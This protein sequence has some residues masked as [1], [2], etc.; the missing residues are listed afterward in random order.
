MH[1]SNHRH[2]HT[3]EERLQ[4]VVSTNMHVCGIPDNYYDTMS[5]QNVY[6]ETSGFTN[7]VELENPAA[8]AIPVTCLLLLVF[9]F[10]FVVSLSLVLVIRFVLFP[11]AASSSKSYSPLML[12]NVLILDSSCYFYS[13][14]CSQSYS[15]KKAS[16]AA[17][18]HQVQDKVQR[19]QGRYK[20]LKGLTRALRAL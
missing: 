3:K 8:K 12:T 20:P 17:N 7:R 5:A 13:F 6:E 14:S 15:N 16:D 19:P 9:W 1:T 10:A 18:C 4:H 2:K 11:Y